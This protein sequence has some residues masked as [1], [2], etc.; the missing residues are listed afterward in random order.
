MVWVY[1]KLKKTKALQ[2]WTQLAFFQVIAS[3]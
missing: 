2:L 1:K 3:Y